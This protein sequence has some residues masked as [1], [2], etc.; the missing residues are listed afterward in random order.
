MVILPSRGLLFSRTFEELL[1]ELQPYDHRIYFA[2]ELPIPDCFNVPLER[3]LKDKA[4]TH[5]LFC[6]DDMA[7]PKGILERMLHLDYPAVAL[8]YPFKQNG[9]S[10]VLHDPKGYALYTGTGFLLVW[11]EVL[12][13]MPKP[14]FRTDI[15]WEMM[16]RKTGRLE[17]WPLD[18]SHKQTYG[19]H[20]VQFGLTMWTNGMP[21]MV[22]APAGQRKLVALGKPGTNKG[23]HKIKLLTKTG[24][25][26]I[27]KNASPQEIQKFL[28][29]LS[30][31]NEVAVLAEAP[32]DILYENGI[33][34]L[35]SEVY[36]T[37]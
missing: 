14:I 23:K 17:F 3:A 2:H 28:H 29:A 8:D 37:I 15:A 9:D 4:V 33:P 18:V 34:K 5:I 21:I 36:E 24:T 6:E 11:R 19:L 12:D 31:V 10:T 20:D 16:V 13:K 1:R 25:D 22:A 32:N 27:T 7:I 35:T 26:N 30:R